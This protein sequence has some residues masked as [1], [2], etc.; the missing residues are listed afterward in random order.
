M[1]P[2]VFDQAL[3]R[4]IEFSEIARERFGTYIKVN[5]CG[6]GEP[7]LNRHTPEFVG[8]IRAAG[9]ECSMSSNGSLLDERRTEAL[10]AAGLQ[11]VEINVGE[12]DDDYERIYGLPFEK[13]C[14]NVVRFA[15][16]AG[17]QCQV[18]IVLVNHRRDRAHTK[19]M[20]DFWRSHG[21]DKFL[22]YDVMN[23]GGSL[24]VDEMQYATFQERSEAASIF[25]ACEGK[26]RAESE[27]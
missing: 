13:T 16:M 26:Q 6:L 25:A 4:T 11:A 17:D 15:E 7:L 9:F 1:K 12:V 20:M 24:F 22:P 23:R 18:R 8:K 10:L 3:A 19:K 27:R 5:L 21:I 14:E 2:E